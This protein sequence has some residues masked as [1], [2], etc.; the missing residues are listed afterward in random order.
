M[1]NKKKKKKKLLQIKYGGIH[2]SRGKYSRN[3]L[4]SLT[5]TKLQGFLVFFFFCC[6]VFS[7]K[8]FS[9]RLTFVDS[10]QSN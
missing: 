5:I 9:L 3:K 2:M 7:C 8:H 4:T 1:V 10:G 6:F